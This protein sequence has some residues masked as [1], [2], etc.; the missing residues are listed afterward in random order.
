MHPPFETHE[1]HSVRR[2]P[3]NPPPPP[4]EVPVLALKVPEAAKSIG[5]SAS[6]M[7]QLIRDGKIKAVRPSDGRTI[8]PVDELKRYL[9]SLVA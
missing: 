8:I 9:A 4:R 5:I 6:L 1:R 3:D 7:Y 2:N